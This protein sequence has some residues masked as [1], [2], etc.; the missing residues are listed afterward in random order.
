MA[1]S[2]RRAPDVRVY[3]F[4][5]ASESNLEQSAPAKKRT[6]ALG[7]GARLGARCL[8][9]IQKPFA[10]FLKSPWPLAMHS[11]PSPEAADKASKLAAKTAEDLLDRSAPPEE[12]QRRKRRLIRGP[13]EFREMRKDQPKR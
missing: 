6:E 12:Q 11:A 1:L 2:R 8:Q 3:L 4:L 7:G 13:S 5:A 10:G 9:Q